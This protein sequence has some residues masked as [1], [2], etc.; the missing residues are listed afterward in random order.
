M[1]TILLGQIP[2]AVFF[3]LFM[4]FAKNIKEKRI[5]F[6]SLMCIEYVLIMAVFQY[7]WLFHILYTIMTFL[8][9]KLLYKEKAQ[10]TDIF[11]LMVSYII[12]ITTSI[13]CVILFRDTVAAAIVNRIIIFLLLIVCNKKLNKIQNVY[14]K[15]WN[16]ND[17]AKKIK[18]T[19]FRSLN[20]VIFNLLFYIINLGMTIALLT[21][22]GGE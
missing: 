17:T 9:L 14:K 22:N 2:E 4:I 1:L 20:L 19:T 6:I 7:N 18:T 3:A 12:V 8:T 16:R 21:V 11:I 13:L 15:Y 5:L 10:V